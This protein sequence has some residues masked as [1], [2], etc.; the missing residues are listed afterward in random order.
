LALEYV[1]P[2]GYQGEDG[3]VSQDMEVTGHLPSQWL[4]G[5]G[6]MGHSLSSAHVMVALAKF[7]GRPVSDDG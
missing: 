4:L 6:S 3:M 1:N 2:A 7:R 5:E